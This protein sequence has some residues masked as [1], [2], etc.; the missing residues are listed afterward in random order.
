MILIATRWALAGSRLFHKYVGK[1]TFNT[2][3]HCH[4][5]NLSLTPIISLGLLTSKQ[6]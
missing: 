3:F 1:V 5:P 6:Q 4:P 2:I